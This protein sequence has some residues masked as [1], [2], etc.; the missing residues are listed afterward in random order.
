[1]LTSQIAAVNGALASLVVVAVYA[2]LAELVANKYARSRWAARGIT[3]PPARTG[4]SLI[5]VGVPVAVAILWLLLSGPYAAVSA[6]VVSWLATLAWR[7]DVHCRKIPREA[8]WITVAIVT[9]VVLL[10]AA[11]TVDWALSMLV[12]AAVWAVSFVSRLG[13]GD[14]RF[15]LAAAPLGAFA[16]APVFAA[17]IVFAGA[18][19]G[20]YRWRTR[21]PAREPL[22]FAPRLAVGLI[23]GMTIGLAVG[24]ATGM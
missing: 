2:C 5:A 1:M 7:T 4:T 24:A 10:A 22:P 3:Y 17:G 23:G 6:G 13:V 12:V 21:T 11:S 20:V 9:V 16:T 14:V 19:Q 18:L 15:I 8:C